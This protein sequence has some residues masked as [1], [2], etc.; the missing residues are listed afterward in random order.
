MQESEANTTLLGSSAATVPGPV[1]MYIVNDSRP[2]NK[3]G[4][5]FDSALTCKC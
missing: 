2:D 1:E 5:D 4:I 3:G